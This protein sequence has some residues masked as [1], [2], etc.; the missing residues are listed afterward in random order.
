MHRM[1]VQDQKHPA[2]AT[3]P[4]CAAAAPRC[5]QQPHAELAT[6]ELTDHC[7]RPP[8]QRRPQLAGVVAHH[9]PVQAGKLGARASWWPSGTGRAV[10]ASARP[11]GI[12][13]ARHPPPPGSSQRLGD[14]GWDGRL[15]RGGDR[16]D[17]QLLQRLVVQLAAVVLTHARTDQ[18]TTTTSSYLMNGLVT[19]GR[20]Q[21]IVPAVV[22][23]RAKGSPASL[24][25]DHTGVPPT[26]QLPEHWDEAE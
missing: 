5:L 4:A 26:P 2:A 11:C 12:W 6:G 20:C 15:A 24:G 23:D 1:V 13:P 9:Q 10:S 8:R 3:G 7:P 19:G 18:I 22:E 14:L 21:Q 16:A 25:R 17:A